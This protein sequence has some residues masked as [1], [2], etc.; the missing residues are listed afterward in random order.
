MKN[1]LIGLAEFTVFMFLLVVLTDND[2]K[3]DWNQTTVAQHEDASDFLEIT[4]ENFPD[5]HSVI[6]DYFEAKICTPDISQ[7]LKVSEIREFTS[8]AQFVVLYGL[9]YTQRDGRAVEM[10]NY[11]TLI[12]GFKFLNCGNA[13]ALTKY[14]IATSKIAIELN[15]FN[16]KQK[17]NK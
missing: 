16:E 3:K 11:N 9:K 7:K 5:I 2:I 4:N 10:A 8:S 15:A 1:L 14:A 12:N 6:L 17:V 13:E